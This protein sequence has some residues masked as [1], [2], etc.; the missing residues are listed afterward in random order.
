M[1]KIS[2]SVTRP[3]VGCTTQFLTTAKRKSGLARAALLF[4]WVSY[5]TCLCYGE[6]CQYTSVYMT[7]RVHLIKSGNEQF[8]AGGIAVIAVAV[9]GVYLLVISQA[10]SPYANSEAENGAPANGGIIQT[11]GSGAA[12]GGKYVQFGTPSSGGMSSTPV[13]PTVPTGGWHVDLADDFN[14]PLGTSAGQDNL[15]YPTQSWNFTPSNN[16]D[17]DNGYETQVYNSNH[18]SVSGGNLILSAS[19]QNNVAPATGNG[20]GSDNNNRVQRNY[21]AGIVTSPTNMSGYKGFNWTPGGGSTWAFEIKCQFPQNTGELFNAWWTSSQG[22][23]QNERDFFEGHTAQSDI[24]TDWIYNTSPFASNYYEHVLNFDPSAATHTYTY[25]VNPDQS[26]SLYIDGFLQTWV[27]SNGVGPVQSGVN[28][29]MELLM[30]YALSRTTFTSGTRQFIV[31]SVA[32]YQDAPHAGQFTSGGGTA[33]GT[34]V[35]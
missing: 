5:R 10:Q 35:Q 26:W 2:V 15:W 21:V 13:G 14:A 4:M 33:P 31:N 16:V 25:V 1:D 32:V 12:S 27:G 9:V 11:D 28:T 30:N 23:W 24:D 18:V 7:K 6:T 19:Y 3:D 20:S 17:G 22:T 8:L 29:P 34:I